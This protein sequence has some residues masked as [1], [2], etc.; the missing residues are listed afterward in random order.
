MLT[1]ELKRLALQ[2]PHHMHFAAVAIKPQAEGV[3]AHLE[4]QRLGLE[5]GHLFRAEVLAVADAVFG[6]SGQPCNS[7]TTII[8]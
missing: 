2:T 6:V 4:L 8:A 1:K 7:S 3:L 5:A